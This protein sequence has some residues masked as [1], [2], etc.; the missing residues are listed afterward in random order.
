MNLK[1]INNLYMNSK[2]TVRN[3]QLLNGKKKVL[4]RYSGKGSSQMTNRGIKV[5]HGVGRKR[6]RTL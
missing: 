1:Y 6:S 4:K 3:K 2:F 5:A